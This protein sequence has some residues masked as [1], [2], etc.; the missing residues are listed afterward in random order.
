VDYRQL[1]KASFETVPIDGINLSEL[2]PETATA[3]VS[4][5]IY[6]TTHGGKLSSRMCNLERDSRGFVDGHLR[7]DKAPV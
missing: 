4:D 5:T 1:S 7:P 2:D 3:L 6:D